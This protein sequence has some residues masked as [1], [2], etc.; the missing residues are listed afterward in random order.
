MFTQ[1]AFRRLAASAL[2]LMALAAIPSLAQPDTASMSAD[3]YS[4]YSDPSNE[5][6]QSPL[7]KKFEAQLAWKSLD[8]WTIRLNEYKSR[9]DRAV[10]PCDLAELNRLRVYW[11]MFLDEK[12]WEGVVDGV[13]KIFGRGFAAA[14]P[15]PSDTY[16][17]SAYDTAIAAP[18]Y[19]GEEYGTE[20]V[21]VYGE[22]GE[23]AVQLSIDVELQNVDAP[24]ASEDEVMIAEAVP[25]SEY[26]A[27]AEPVFGAEYYQQGEP[28]IQGGEG[29]WTSM[30]PQ[31]VEEVDMEKTMQ[32]VDKVSEMVETFFVA[33]WIARRYRPE[34][35]RIRRT[36]E[37]DLSSFMDTLFVFRDDFV[38]QHSAELANY[39]EMREELDQVTR[40]ELDK[41]LAEME[42]EEWAVIG[43]NM[44][45]E[46]LL[47]LYN[48]QDMRGL[49][50]EVDALP[51][52]ITS[53]DIPEMS[54]LRQ[55]VPNPAATETTITYVLNEESR[56]TV[57]RLYNAR[58]EMVIQENLGSRSAG[59]HQAELDIAGLPT[60]SYLYHLT[61][62]GSRGEQVHSKTMQIV[63]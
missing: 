30:A 25:E 11:S 37:T 49:L 46:P 24:E 19:D 47:L 23:E 38:R 20:P 55:N 61:V 1:S 16:D 56:R 7:M 62:Q 4:G 15:A 60:G 18:Y 32:M 42:G 6:R 58:G 14:V 48:G 44:V 33:K 50:R 57:L 8:Y 39:P 31:Q 34:F 43:Y 17:Y 52:E 9:I 63:R 45:V 10:D 22:T 13:G 54:A 21:E 12:K 36:L 28:S 26:D 27:S 40:G 29:G 2:L 5:W 41:A 53:L 3:E 35:D 59:Q 51:A